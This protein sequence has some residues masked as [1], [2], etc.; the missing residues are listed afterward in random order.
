M[1]VLDLTAGE[2]GKTM[3]LTQGVAEPFVK[4]TVDS[5]ASQQRSALGPTTGKGIDREG[6]MVTQMSGCRFSLAGIMV[7]PDPQ[8]RF[9]EDRAVS[10]A[11]L[12]G[13][14]QFAGIAAALDNPQMQIQAARYPRYVP[15]PGRRHD[16]EQPADMDIVAF[17]QI[18]QGGKCGRWIAPKRFALGRA[19]QDH[20]LTP[21]AEG[22][23]PAANPLGR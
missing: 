18:H 3:A 17:V 6:W 12:V 23:A 5:P 9:G 16:R 8:V 21:P 15:Y 1:E 10:L 22:K 13:Q 7:D 20:D 4:K 19:E 14:D 11:K 2:D